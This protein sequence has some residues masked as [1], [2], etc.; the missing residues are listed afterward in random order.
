MLEPKKPIKILA[1]LAL[2]GIAF[3]LIG[4]VASTRN[5][6]GQSVGTLFLTVG[7]VVL[8]ITFLLYVSVSKN[9][10]NRV[11]SYEEYDLAGYLDTI[12]QSIAN[13]TAVTF[14]KGKIVANDDTVY[15]NDEYVAA[16]KFDLVRNAY[17]TN[18]IAGQYKY[19]QMAVA[20][21]C[22]DGQTRYMYI[23]P[24]NRKNNPDFDAFIK[25]V[26]EHV[27]AQGGV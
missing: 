5:G 15:L 14:N 24:R 9:W 13:G 3:A 19:N 12:K 20:L 1:G 26:K 21:E 22:T 4:L 17:R 23:A 8:F 27:V 10:K 25:Y 11:K 16:I 18:I 7:F 2:A 6:L